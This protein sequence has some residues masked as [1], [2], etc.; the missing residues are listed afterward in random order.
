M[1][2][3]FPTRFPLSRHG[4][5]AFIVPMALCLGSI[6]GVAPAETPFVNDAEMDAPASIKD[7]KKW[8]EQSIAMPAWPKDADLVA[9]PVD[10]HDARFS[11][12]I[13]TRSLKT[14]SDD[15]VRYILVAESESGARNLSYEGMRCTPKGRYKIYGYGNGGRFSPSSI[16]GRWIDIDQRAS[17][18]ARFELWRHYF[19]VPRLFEPRPKRDQVR[20]LRS[21]RVPDVETSG[22]LSN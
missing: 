5:K 21:G 18:T 11:H 16:A 4:M 12:W 6:A 20:M 9:I 7:S 15:V 22:F 1:P 3:I 8:Q 17:E 2:I 13:D 19:C 14:G 10:D